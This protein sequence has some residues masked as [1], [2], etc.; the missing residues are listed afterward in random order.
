MKAI[1]LTLLG[2][3]GLLALLIAGLVIAMLVIDPNDYKKLAEDATKDATGLTLSLGDIG[4]Q[5]FPNVGLSVSQVRL[6]DDAR[7]ADDNTLVEAE[8]ASVALAVMPLLQQQVRVKEITLHAPMIQYITAADGTTNWDRL[9]Q[10]GTQAPDQSTDTQSNTNPT[11][12]PDFAAEAL[13]ISQASLRLV[14]KKANTSTQIDNFNLQ[15]KDVALDKAIPMAFSVAIEQ[16]NTLDVALKGEGHLTVNQALN[17]FTLSALNLT[18]NINKAPGINGAQT[19]TLSLD[20]DADL[21]KNLATVSQ[22]QLQLADLTLNGNAEITQLT[23]NPQLNTTLKINTFSPK[24]WVPKVL[25]TPLPPT[26]NENSLTAVA[27][28]T[29][30]IGSLT[31]DNPTLKVAPLTLNLD[32]STLKGEATVNL[33]TQAITSQLNLDQINLDHYLPPAPPETEADTHSD[34]DANTTA[35][36]TADNAPQTDKENAEAPLIPIAALR[37]LQANI[38]FTANRLIAQEMSIENLKLNA[39]ANKGLIALNTF[40]ANVLGGTISTQGA[41]DVRSDTPQIKL[42]HATQTLKLHP[43]IMAFLGKDV[44]DGAVSLSANL[45]TQGNTTQSLIKGLVGNSQ[46]RLDDG[47]LKGINLTEIAYNQLNEWGP[48]VASLVPEDYAQR[49]P[50]AFQKNTGIKNLLANLEFKD[51]K[52][53]TKNLDADVQ[54]SQV[55][56]EGEIDMATLGGTMR[57][58]LKLSESL[59]NPTLAQLTWPII[60]HFQATGAPDCDLKTTPV[61]REIEKL[62]K[63]AL[64]DKAKAALERKLREKLGLEQKQAAEAAAKAKIAAE[65]AAAEAKLEAEKAAAKAKLEAEKAAAKAKI[66]EEEERAKE[67]AIDA[68]RKL[69]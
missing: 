21:A 56:G 42:D 15:L 20:A 63:R 28:E 49:V 25:G 4:W 59:T 37:P 51:G 61:R 38:Q 68:L 12:L 2:V 31:G 9:T 19:A 54:G 22:L 50:P 53:L 66:R 60:C 41:L 45:S 47:L 30:V 36:T 40:S 52:I 32:Q 16:D 18:A 27:L 6:T 26:A 46:F 67:K 65:K 39:D 24:Q 29:T 69:F 1:K 33:N 64:E 35:N 5:F 44:A 8:G 58:N 7:T 34:T 10:T 48:L 62:A 43:V 3:F 11:A 17:R 23:E 13:E 55:N 57:L 14:D